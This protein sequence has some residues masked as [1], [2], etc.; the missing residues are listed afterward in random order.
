MDDTSALDD[1]KPGIELYAPQRPS[2]VKAVDGAAQKKGMPDS[3][4]V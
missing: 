4:D 3:E 2:W 1:M